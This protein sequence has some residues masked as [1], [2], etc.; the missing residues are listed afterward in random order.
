MPLSPSPASTQALHAVLDADMALSLDYLDAQQGVGAQLPPDGG[1]YA[2]HLPMAVHALHALGCPPDQLRSW[3]RDAAAQLPP[4][5]PWPAL[6]EAQARAAQAL[7]A[8]GAAPVL[9]KAL[10]GLMPAAGAMGFHALIRTAH[11]WES[12]HIGQLARAL[13]YWQVRAASAPGPWQPPRPAT[14]RPLA[15]WL[16]ALLALPP[17]PPGPRLGWISTRMGAWAQLPAVQAVAPTLQTGPDTLPQ[18]IRWAAQA[19]ADSGNFTLLHLVTAS[20]AAR[21]LLPLL[22]HAAQPAALQAFSTQ[23]ALGLLASGWRGQRQAPLDAPGWSDLRAAVLRHGDEHVIKLAHAA[24][25]GAADDPE[26][27]PDPVWRQAVARSLL[28]FTPVTPG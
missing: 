28:V 11:A 17:A 21:V 25:Q 14:P 18:L 2:S 4:A 9:A 6:E 8:E 26:A 27:H 16:A 24:L 20:R 23:A 7:A 15:D 5:P 10:P 19:Y 12:G 3:G 13:A 22:P 1:A